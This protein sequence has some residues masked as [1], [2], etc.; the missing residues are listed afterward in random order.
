MARINTLEE[1]RE[2]L[3]KRFFR[4]AIMLE[5][6]CLH[7]LL[8]NKRDFDVLNKLW[9]PKIFQ[10]LTVNTVRFRKSFFLNNSNHDYG[11]MTDSFKD[12]RR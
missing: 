4:R 8:P 3:T 6:S 11:H 12:I 7:Y 10:L 1:R 5:S 2:V 9:F